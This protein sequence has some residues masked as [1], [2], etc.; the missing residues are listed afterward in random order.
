MLTEQYRRR[1]WAEV[2]GQDKVVQR[3]QALAQRGLAC[4]AYRLT[5]QR[6]CFQERDF[7]DLFAPTQVVS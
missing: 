7:L 6:N 5:G 1:T 2:V 3:V 4:R